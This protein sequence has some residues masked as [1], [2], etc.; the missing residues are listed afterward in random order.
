M[1]SLEVP[2]PLTV[3][4]TVEG[5]PITMEVDS[6]ASYSLVGY[7]IYKNLFTQSPIYNA[8]ICLAVYSNDELPVLGFIMVDVKYL[9]YQTTFQWQTVMDQHFWAELGLTR[10][11]SV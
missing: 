11:R 5:K 2:P 6:G 9:N 10:Y 8:N 4:L 3:D 1:P 7:Q